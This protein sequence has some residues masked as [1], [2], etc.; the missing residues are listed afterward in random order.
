MLVFLQSGHTIHC[1]LLASSPPPSSYYD[2]LR[3]TTLHYTGHDARVCMCVCVVLAGRGVA[4]GEGAT[5]KLDVTLLPCHPLSPPC[6]RVPEGT[7]GSSQEDFKKEWRNDEGKDHCESKHLT[8]KKSL[9]ER[10]SRRCEI[11]VTVG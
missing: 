4:D 9:G 8:G 6:V 2:T 3:Y 1:I 5:R 7:G 11:R 10:L